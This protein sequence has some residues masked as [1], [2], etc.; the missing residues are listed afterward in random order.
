M[1]RIERDSDGKIIRYR[2]TVDTLYGELRGL[3]EEQDWRPMGDSSRDKEWLQSIDTRVLDWLGLMHNETQRNTYCWL[4]VWLANDISAPI[5]DWT[6][7]YLSQVADVVLNSSQE[8]NSKTLGVRSRGTKGNRAQQLARDAR[9]IAMARTKRMLMRSEGCNQSQAN[10]LIADWMDCSQV[11]VD[12]QAFEIFKLLE[13][14]K[15]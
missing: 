8:I 14:G 2:R 1:A 6:R 10:R 4:A 12:V 11:N 7:Q 9:N 15:T 3:A 13:A 5:P